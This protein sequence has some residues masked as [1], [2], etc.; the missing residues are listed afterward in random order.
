MHNLAEP[1][2]ASSGR[3]EKLLLTRATLETV[4]HN[5]KRISPTDRALIKL[6]AARRQ[7]S[8]DPNTALRRVL[9]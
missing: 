6:Q 4:S 5:K 8:A 9:S 1:G 7:S 3:R 2:A